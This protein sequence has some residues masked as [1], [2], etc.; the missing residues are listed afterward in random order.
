MSCPDCFRGTE[1]LGNPT[2]TL[3]T[4][5]GLETYVASPGDGVT[6]KGIVVYIP[7]AF[8]MHFVNNKILA[9]HYAKRGGVLVYLPDFMNGN[10]RQLLRSRQLLI[11]TL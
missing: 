9:D 7:D 4:I 11:H 10:L 8:G 3:E 2:G 6:P 5:H 1:H